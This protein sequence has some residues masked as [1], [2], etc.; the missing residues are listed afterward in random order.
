MF[1]K[2]NNPINFQGNL[3]KK[4][5]FEGWYYKCVSADGNHSIAFIPGISLTKEDSHSFIQ[6]FV[7]FKGENLKSTYIRFAKKDFRA[8]ENPF[9]VRINLN[10]FTEKEINVELKDETLQVYGVLNFEDMKKIETN[11]KSPSIMGFFSYFSF[12]ECN[13][14]VMSMNHTLKG[15][16]T[17]NGEIVN[18]DGGRGYI[19]KDWGTSF[20]REYVWMQSNHFERPDIS[21]MFSEAIIP[22][23][24]FNFDGLIVNLVANNKEYRFATYNGA[25]VVAKKI[26]KKKVYYEITRNNLK[27]V[28][29]AM[30]DKTV[31]LPSPK[32]GAM[33]Q[34]IKEGL[35]G[36]IKLKLYEN[37]QLIVDDM[38]QNAGLEIMMSE[39]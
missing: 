12:M 27:L 13:H 33:N 4:N 17:I 10:I 23:K 36:K 32:N 2:I 21:F 39:T 35:S 18:F 37:N 25:K 14:G 5:Y 29:E 22:F 11:W 26:T 30:N 16:L 34:S 7:S 8:F 9:S 31:D 38:G 28:V 15:K 3:N 20:P 24:I 6:M 1:K 19:E